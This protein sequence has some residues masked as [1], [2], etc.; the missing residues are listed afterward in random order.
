MT[1]V[2]WPSRAEGAMPSRTNETERLTLFYALALGAVAALYRLAPYAYQY[3]LGATA[4]EVLWNLMPVGV[5][6]IS[7][8]LLIVPIHW[9]TDGRYAALGWGRPLIY[10]SFA[11]YS[12]LGRLVG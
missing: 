9:L 2:P 1:C 5:M 7:D 8:L 4:P 6:F 11:V 12:L 3:L 10:A